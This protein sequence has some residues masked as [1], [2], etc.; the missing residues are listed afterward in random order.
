MPI[1]FLIIWNFQ[2]GFQF[3]IQLEQ[4]YP[5]MCKSIYFVK[6]Q[7]LPAGLYY[8]ITIQSLVRKK[9]I[10]WIKLTKPFYQFWEDTRVTF[11]QTPI[12]GRTH[13]PCLDSRYL[14]TSSL[15]NGTKYFALLAVCLCFDFSF[16]IIGARNYR[17]KD[18]NL[19]KNIDLYLLELY[20]T[21]N[22]DTTINRKNHLTQ[23]VYISYVVFGK[24][25][26]CYFT[27]NRRFSL[28]YRKYGHTNV[29]FPVSKCVRALSQY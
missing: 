21:M 5:Y 26:Y 23:Y 10:S 22:V 8:L 6:N 19:K 17:K 11:N 15:V 3:Y 7:V 14:I 9:N 25:K 12:S 27:P 2:N 16:K 29:Q 1:T 13:F 4:I 28:N 20:S 24:N 18:A